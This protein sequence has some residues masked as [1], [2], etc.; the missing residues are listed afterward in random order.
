MFAFN[1]RWVITALV[2]GACPL[3]GASCS[4]SKS[5]AGGSGGATAGSGGAPAGGTKADS[6]SETDAAALLPA[7]VLDPTGTYAGKT[8]AEWAAAWWKW[9]MEL[10]GPDFPVKDSTGALCAMGQFGGG[11]GGA[12]AND[13]FFLA[14][15]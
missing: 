5:P 7:P 11:D 4:S 12:G 8:Y 14:D 3:A 10:P 1:R 6:G 9:I 15:A 13:I 2:L